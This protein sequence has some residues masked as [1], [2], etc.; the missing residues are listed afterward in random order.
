MVRISI[1]GGSGNVAREFI[2]ALLATNNHTII[3][4]TRTAPKD[5]IDARITQRV[6]DYDS[7]EQLVDS[8]HGIH[9]V[10]SFI[11]ILSDVDQKAQKNIIDAAIKAGVKRFAPSEYGSAGTTNMPWY[12]GKQKIREYLEKVN[13]TGKVLEYCLFQPG[14]FLNYLAFPHK[15]SKHL[16]PLGTVFDYQNK[17]ALLVEGHE[18][19]LMTL[20]T[21]D[22]FAAIMAR[23][24]DYHGEWPAVGGIQGNKVT[25]TAIVELGQRLRGQ[26]LSV[27]KV[28]IEDLEEGKLTSSWGL[29]VPHKSVSK[30]KATAMLKQVT[31]GMLLS[32]AKGAWDGSDELNRMFSEYS[33]TSMEDFLSKGWI[34]K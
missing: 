29:E 8:L 25:V 23:A 31:I 14:L 3:V 6:V 30:E 10:L 32:T 21:V 9:T 1:A 22:D 15:T 20:T 7:P 34:K 11:Q 33:F 16:S 4:L 12:E 13:E 5:D 2:D 24:V 17:R 18:D 28:K 27:E 26:P 19:A